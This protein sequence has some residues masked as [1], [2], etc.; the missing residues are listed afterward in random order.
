MATKSIG[1][2]QISH[3]NVNR[4]EFK[5]YFTDNRYHKS[6]SDP[7]INNFSENKQLIFIRKTPNAHFILIVHVD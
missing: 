6:L 4:R 1:K 7:L 5:P 2:K 3:S